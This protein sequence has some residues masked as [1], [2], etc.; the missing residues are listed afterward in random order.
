MSLFAE[1]NQARLNLKM[2]L[3]NYSW[4]KSSVV[5][6]ENG[7]YLIVVSVRNINNFVKKTVNKAANN[8]KIKIYED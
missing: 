1:A 2:Q 3:S 7:D 4:Y 8:I 6:S 5:I